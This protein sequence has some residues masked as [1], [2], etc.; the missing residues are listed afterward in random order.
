MLCDPLRHPALLAK[1]AATLDV[2][3]EGRLEL[4]LGWGSVES[5][6][7]SYGFGAMPAA[8][9]A[10]RL[11]ETLKILELMFSGQ[12]FSFEGR[13]FRLHD[14][15]GRPT[16]VQGRVPIHLGG[17]GAR[18][19][20]PLVAAHADWWNCPA[21]GVEALDRLA[22]LAGR[23]RVS[24]QHPVG[25]APSAATRAQV[26]ELTRRR[27]GSWGG[28]VTGTPEEV[29]AQLSAEVARGVEMF[30]VQFHDFAQPPTLELFA[31]EVIPRVRA[32]RGDGRPQAP[33]ST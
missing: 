12:P 27:F 15:V 13:H 32:A 7:V 25:L 31:R 23:A 1:M 16:P 8:E 26:E 21:Y 11:G 28:V 17:A 30:V 19:T 4:G 2:I 33:P 20:M 29:A 24:V 14:A 10:G 6:L 5:E 22:P 3:C 9:R 18:L